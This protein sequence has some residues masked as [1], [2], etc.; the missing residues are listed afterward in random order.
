L[1]ASR[2]NIDV[3]RRGQEARSTGRFYE[4]IHTLD[5]DIEWDI[6]GHPL[7]DFPECGVGRDLFIGHVAKYWSRWNDYAQ[8]VKRTIEVGDDVVVIL[9]ERARERNSDG[10]RPRS[11]NSLN[12]PRYGVRVRFRAFEDS[13]DALRAAGIDQ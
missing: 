3:V 13:A 9:L 7:P 11:R 10:R 4:W 6:S 5:P 8:T 1:T 12:R 2:D